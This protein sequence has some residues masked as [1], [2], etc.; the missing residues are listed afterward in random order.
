MQQQVPVITIFVRHSAGCP[1][2]ADEFFKR[3]SCW[4]HLRWTA[5]GGKQ[6]RK[7]TKQKTWAGAERVKRE[8]ELSYETSGEPVQANNPTTIQQAV[9]TFLRAK[10]GKGISGEEVAKYK[11]RLA[12][13]TEFCEKD[14]HYFLRDVS[15]PDL[16]NFRATWEAQYPSSITRQKVQEL[17]RS[18]FRYAQ[19]AEWISKNPAADLD[20]VIAEDPQVFPLEP[21][22]YQALL[23]KVPEVFPD[24]I[25]A[26]RIRALI[27]CMRFTG[28]AIS[29]AWS[30][31][32]AKIQRDPNRGVTHVKT[33]RLKTGA[34]VGVAIPRDVE[35]ELL[36]VP[37]TNPHYVFWQPGDGAMKK[38]LKKA[39]KSL[40]GTLSKLFHAAGLPKGH[41]HQLRHTAAVE[42]LKA[43][44]P[45]EEVSRLLGHKTIRTTEKYYNAW[46]KSRQ[47]RLDAL[48]MATWDGAVTHWTVAA[49]KKLIDAIEAN[50]KAIKELSQYAQMDTAELVEHAL[51]EF[52]QSHRN[53][54]AADRDT[55]RS[56]IST[57]NPVGTSPESTERLAAEAA[58]ISFPRPALNPSLC[59]VQESPDIDTGSPVNAIEARSEREPE[60]H[61]VHAPSD[62]CSVLGEVSRASQDVP[63]TALQRCHATDA[64][65][66]SG[67]GEIS[68]GAQASISID[69]VGTVTLA[70]PAAR[71][72]TETSSVAVTPST[73]MVDKEVGKAKEPTREELRRARKLRN[74]KRYLE[75]KKRLAQVAAADAARPGRAGDWTT[76]SSTTESS[77]SA[78]KST[79]VWSGVQPADVGAH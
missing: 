25:E 77:S 38:A 67:N 36:S 49:R 68:S 27:R 55:V 65:T 13:L 29:D 37:N 71:P 51:E 48:V 78:P 74:Q 11:C 5:P 79:A 57:S 24:P 42:W 26:A 59:V 23:D 21:E 10:T 40:T 4:K 66:P 52:L 54:G 58:E 69:S 41:S 30:L 7:A 62:R 31:E 1:H 61:R 14:G 16:T 46:V 76:I 64:V 47:D 39:V 12:R 60:E 43:G 3:C 20:P 35:E 19:R 2:A 45:L 53:S 17:L 22:E 6:Q 50:I 70:S 75:K 72:G 34:Y 56:F 28:L 8:R 32:R 73:S 18:F 44:I 63:Q 9:E 33:T 15:L